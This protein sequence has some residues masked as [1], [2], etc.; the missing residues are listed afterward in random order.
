VQL[1]T[2]CYLEPK[3]TYLGIVFNFYSGPVHLN[4]PHLNMC[5]GNMCSHLNCWLFAD[6]TWKLLFYSFQ[7]HIFSASLIPTALEYCHRQQM[8][9]FLFE[10]NR[11]KCLFLHFK[12]WHLLQWEC[13]LV[14]SP[15][16]VILTGNNVNCR[17]LVWQS[18]ELYTFSY[19]GTWTTCGRCKYVWIIIIL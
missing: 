3:I 6:L 16:N 19:L 5:S 9:R 2:N 1:A 10:Q 14:S 13:F 7:C 17:T 18:T 8:S 11:R 15:V 4:P 12:Y